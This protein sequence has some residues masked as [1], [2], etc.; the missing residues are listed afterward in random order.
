MLDADQYSFHTPRAVGIL[1]DLVRT[2][3]RGVEYDVK[4][5][6]V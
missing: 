1:N 6:I 4:Q 3:S 2:G 5:V